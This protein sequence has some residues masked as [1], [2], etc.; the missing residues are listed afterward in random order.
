MKCK[1][2]ITHKF[3]TRKMQNRASFAKHLAAYEYVKQFA[4]NKVVLDAGTSDGYGAYYLSESAKEIAGI[5]INIDRIGRAESAYKRNNL[6]FLVNDVLDIKFPNEYF[7]IVVSSQV[8]EHIELDK[9]D[10][11]LSEIN[12]VLKKGGLFFVITVNLINNLKGKSLQEYNKSPY[13]AKEFEPYEL[14]SFL[15]RCFSEVE[16]LGLNKGI[17]HHLYCLLKKSGL[18]SK[19]P[20]KF[21]L[22]K[23]FYNRTID[24]TDFKWSYHNLDR[25]FDLM[26]RCRK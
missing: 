14:K 15:S 20:E 16:L 1:G 10:R 25:S 4:T 24:L 3:A 2:F 7:D 26:G 6:K 17:R 19:V 8:V 22:V 23:R 13:H 18:F 11:Y 9:L 21:N 12:R 5:D